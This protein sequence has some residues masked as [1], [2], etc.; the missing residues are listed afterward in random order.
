M[1]NEKMQEILQKI[2]QL[3]FE[4]TVLDRESKSK[5]AER[6]VDISA[7][8]YDEKEAQGGLQTILSNWISQG[9]KVRRFENEFAKYI[10][11]KYAI[12]VNSGSSANLLALSSVMEAGDLKAEDEI[13]VPAT[14]FPTVVSPII[15]I[16]CIPVYVDVDIR[17]YNIDPAAIERA[18]S[19]K[20]KWLM[21]VH[22]V[23][24]PA[25]MPKIMEIAR[26]NN[27]RVIEDCC[28]AHGAAINGKKVGSFG[29]ISTFSFFVAHNMTT[30][31]GGMILTSN[32]LYMKNCRSMREFGRTDQADVQKNRFY[33]DDILKDYDRRY[34]FERLGYN[35]RMTDVTASFGIEQLKK[36]GGF[37]DRRRKNAAYYSDYLK[38]YEKFLQTPLIEDGR[39][40]SF[41]TYPILIRPDSGVSRI[42]LVSFLEK[43]GIETRSIFAGCLPDQP[44]FR[45]QP[46]RIGGTLKNARIIRD[47]GFFIGVHSGLSEADLQHVCR[48]FDV[49]FSHHE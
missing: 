35:I 8:V 4:Y 45:H 41:Y 20:T 25:D 2:D 31:E 33:S 12:A 49:F 26:R 30:G 44:A 6:R 43:N 13:I 24:Y 23:G 36:L 14:T 19:P 10:G 22:T 11:T 17:T 40:H 27:L 38:K 1:N 3:I 16:G 48:T 47:Y 5:N 37:N 39:L 21:P 9:P 7:A 28:E 18:L 34:I 29:D 46:Y 32:E 42:K 15:Q